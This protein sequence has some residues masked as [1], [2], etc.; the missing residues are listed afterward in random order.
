MLRRAR[1]WWSIS[2]AEISSSF[3]SFATSEDRAAS[4]TIALFWYK[5]ITRASRRRPWRQNAAWK[6]R[7][8]AALSRTAAAVGLS[9]FLKLELFFLTRFP[10]SA[11]ISECSALL[12][13]WCS[14][15]D[16]TDVGS[17]AAAGRSCG[18]EDGQTE[19]SPQAVPASDAC[20]S[21]LTFSFIVFKFLEEQLRG[22]LVTTSTG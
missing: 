22:P 17:S 2:S 21:V 9:R 16:F 15:L 12:W 14:L 1:Y 6:G 11:R 8:P 20:V 13:M 4:N 18:C 7:N 5:C 3:Q 10:C 19:A